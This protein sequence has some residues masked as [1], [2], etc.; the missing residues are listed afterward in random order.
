MNYAP[1]IYPKVI[2]TCTNIEKLI[3]SYAVYGNQISIRIIWNYSKFNF[4]HFVSN[5]I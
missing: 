3:E 1:S 4:C 2:F 5:I